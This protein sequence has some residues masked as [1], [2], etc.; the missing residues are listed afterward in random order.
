MNGA[1]TIQPRPGGTENTN[2]CC[3]IPYKDPI[4]IEGSVRV[5]ESV[6]LTKDLT[7]VPVIPFMGI[8][9]IPIP[10]NVYCLLIGSKG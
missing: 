4:I 6:M 2:I 7:L 5:G 3:T 1:I 10:L 8:L 9:G